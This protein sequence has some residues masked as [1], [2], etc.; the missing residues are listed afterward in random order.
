[1]PHLVLGILIMLAGALVMAAG[2]Y[3][4]SVS[5]SSLAGGRALGN[6]AG[7]ALLLLIGLALAV[8]GIIVSFEPGT[9]APK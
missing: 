8:V 4:R 5:A 2:L 7:S 1:M 9:T 3:V 6:L